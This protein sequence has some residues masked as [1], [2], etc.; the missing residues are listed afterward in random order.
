MSTLETRT[1]KSTKRP[2][3][4]IFQANFAMR[5]SIRALK[6]NPGAFGFS[7]VRGRGERVE[8]SGVCFV[9]SL[10]LFLSGSLAA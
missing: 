2:R 4:P 1:L 9:W 6:R 5:M 3:E 7:A 10:H 8:A